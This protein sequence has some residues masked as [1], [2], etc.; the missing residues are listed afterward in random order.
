MSEGAGETVNAAL[1][2]LMLPAVAACFVLAT[3]GCDTLPVGTPSP[4][5]LVDNTPPPAASGLALHNRLVTQLA[6]FAL[7]SGVSELWPMDDGISPAVARDAAR[8]AGF[9]LRP[10]AELKLSRI[11]GSDGGVELVLRTD[12]GTSR[13]NS[14]D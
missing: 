2:R 5:A 13:W 4:G 9:V 1:S 12:D 10:D 14:G 11:V 7:A 3:I 6:A 8:V